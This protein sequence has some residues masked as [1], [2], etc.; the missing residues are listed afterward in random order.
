[1]VVSIGM[2]V[3]DGPWGG[4]NQFG[5]ALAE[6]LQGRGVIVEFD[7][8]RPDIDLILLTEPRRDLKTCAFDDRDISTYRGSV[9]PRAVVVHR[10][11]ECD[12]RKGS[13][14]VNARLREANQVADAT[15]F[16]SSWLRNLHVNQGMT[17]ARPCVILNGADGRIFHPGDSI[18][19]KPG[20][21]LK[22]V[23]HHWGANRLKGHDIYEQIDR[24][25]SDPRISSKISLTY[26]GN[27]PDGTRLPHCRVSEPLHGENLADELRR[28]HV[29]VT[30]S[31]N[32]PAGMHHIEGALCGLPLLYRRSGALPEYCT[33]FGI[34][35]DGSDFPSALKT[36]MATYHVWADRTRSYPYTAER[37][38]E[39]YLSLFS[40][41]LE[42]RVRDSVVMGASNGPVQSHAPKPQGAPW[43]VW[44]KETK[45][46]IS[47]YLD[48]LRD[49]TRAGRYHPAKEGVL[50]TG[51]VMG[52]GF[53]AFATKLHVILGT[54]QKMSQQDRSTHINFIKS[55]QRSDIGPDNRWRSGA[56]ADLPLVH[57]LDQ[58]GE[59]ESERIHTVRGAVRAE[60][61]QA[62]AT[63]AEVNAYPTL[64]YSDLPATA[65]ELRDILQKG[66]WSRPW[67][68]GGQ[69]SAI[70][71]L[72]A[73]G[74]GS[75]PRSMEAELLLSARMFFRSMVDLETGA[76]FSGPRPEYGNLVNGAM[77]VLTALDWLE[78]PIH[79][80]EKL[81]DACLTALPQ[82]EGCHLV[83]VVYVLSRC[84]GQSRHRQRDIA[85]YCTRLLE[86]IRLHQKTDGGFSYWID[87]SQ[88]VYYGVPTM[89]G[90]A[91][92]DLHGTLLLTWALAMITRLIGDDRFPVLQ[93]IRP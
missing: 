46:K 86:M 88:T 91:V 74:H 21:Q 87:K 51:D 25:V 42:E 56:F 37:M 8:H 80:P 54:W 43:P 83:D 60:S 72:L 24:M 49:N 18:R 31:E 57:Y 90:R 7:L 64:R 14:G 71:T 17:P 70:V 55:Y 39:Q 68:A 5:A 12:E 41:L 63:L 78:E 59:Q 53:T 47:S 38:C 19:W 45:E 35:F 11:N 6:Y 9:N 92:S 89:S 10:V 81:I 20:E 76:Y 65:V 29:Y 77:K 3:Q 26:I 62:I 93:L 44:M 27:L 50:P 16:I 1:M 85:E 75:A 36:M 40:R 73:T 52:L 4:G 34:G 13:I 32:E 79:A 61:K 84:S 28:H 58:H 82:H 30:G 48:A 67:A 15:V 66:D 2:R 23:T 22:L 33:D 69:A